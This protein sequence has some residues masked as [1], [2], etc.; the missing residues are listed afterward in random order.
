VRESCPQRGSLA[1]IARVEEA[2]DPFLVDLAQHV[3]CPVGRTIVDDHDILL[4]TEG[5]RHA[6]PVQDRR[7]RVDLVVDG[8]DDR[9][10]PG[11]AGC[12]HRRGGDSER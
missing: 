8:D 1:T 10:C 5:G 12:A 9:E 7:D 3:R 11:C 4:E 2:G 6:H